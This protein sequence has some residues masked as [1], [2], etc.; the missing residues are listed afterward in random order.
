MY[1]LITLRRQPHAARPDQARIGRLK[2][3]DRAADGPFHVDVLVIGPA[4][5][6]VCTS[7]IAIRQWH[8]TEDHAAG[9]L[10][11]DPAD[12]EH[13]PEIAMHIVMDA[14]RAAGTGIVATG[15]RA[16]EC[17]I[18]RVSGALCASW[19]RPSQ[20]CV[21]EHPVGCKVADS[22]RVVIRRHRNAVR[23]ASGR[24]DAPENAVLGILIYGP[25]HV[26]RLRPSASAPWIGEIEVPIGIEV[27]V[28]RSL[29]ELIAIRRD[30][31]AELLR[32]RIV[33]DDA[34]VARGQIELS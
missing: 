6:K 12:A 30:H 17:R 25:S 26:G 14:V 7:G 5:R 4:K 29:E 2:T 32:L 9:I 15:S 18:R 24:Y 19:R 21:V 1:R 11:D 20:K 34:D 10:F 8:V 23:K 3:P 33:D 28:V 16:T 13:G 31:R 22:K 27:E